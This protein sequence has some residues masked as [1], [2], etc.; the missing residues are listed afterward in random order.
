ML[1][2]ILV[3]F[4]L[5]FAER[6]V[7]R[8][9]L[10]VYGVFAV[11]GIAFLIGRFILWHYPMPEFYLQR[12][13]G[14]DY[15][16]W[17]LAKLL[18]YLTGVLFQSP[19]TVGP[20]GRL[21]PWLE[22]PGDYL[23]MTAIVGFLVAGYFCAAYR[24]R[25]VWI[26]PAWILLSLLPVVPMLATPHN[27]YLPSVGFVMG[28]V[29]PAALRHRLRP[30]LIGRWIHVAA[31]FFLV[32]MTS[33]L[34][35]YRPMWRSFI[36]A[37][38]LTVERVAQ[39]PPA[40]TVEDVFF[41]NLPFVNVYAQLHLAERLDRWTPMSPR[42]AA[43]RGWASAERYPGFEVH[44]LTF[45]PDVLRIVEPSMLRQIDAHRFR[46]RLEDQAWFSSALGRYLIEPMR[47]EGRLK[48]GDLV[49]SKGGLFDAKVIAADESGV[50][51]I[52]FRFKRPLASGEYA[53]YLG[54]SGSAA[55]RV[56]FVSPQALD[57]GGPPVELRYPRRGAD[58]AT[59]SIR[60]NDRIARLR[61][62]RDALYRIRQIAAR[63]IG[64]DLYLTGRP[65]PGPR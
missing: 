50:W 32:A 1:P 17:W 12:P 62:E 39:A 38:Q 26:W 23:L 51:E 4:D 8:K 30:I 13:D 57:A 48:S 58:S 16:F 42:Q 44:A 9:R 21:N 11:I 19:L 61:F 41:I 37:E 7:I 54:H 64:S 31:G 60:G 5:S 40:E 35:V 3:L 59:K 52:E 49:S 33:Y 34:F 10:G 63:I 14:W 18:H 53:F 55:E 45:A 29:V 25:G 27:G 47:R 56:M 43:E 15:P 36:A 65:F 24:M 22:A 2:A 28:V 46:V 6:P 20:T